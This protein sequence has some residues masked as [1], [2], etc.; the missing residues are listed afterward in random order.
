MIGLHRTP[1][2]L[3][4]L[5]AVYYLQHLW[6]RRAN[7]AA[8]FGHQRVR[9]AVYASF[10]SQRLLIEQQVTGEAYRLLYLEGE[11]VDVVLRQ[12]PRVTGDG[13]STVH[14]L[15]AAENERRVREGGRVAQTLISIDLDCKTTL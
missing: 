7:R 5:R 11:L 14:A 8:P 2:G 4:L 6:E 10:F 13:H 12:S 1:S 15:I 9:T 3:K